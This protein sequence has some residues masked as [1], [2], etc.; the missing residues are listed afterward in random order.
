[1]LK[2]YLDDVQAVVNTFA[3]A[4]FVVQSTF[5]IDLRPGH[6][7]YLTGRFYFVDGS[8]LH[9]RE[10]VDATGPTIEKV[11]YTYHYQ[12]EEHQLIFRYDNAHHRPPLAF[13]EHK[14]TP[15]IIIQA[16]APSLEAVLLEIVELRQFDHS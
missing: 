7:A 8:V 16:K 15:D 12:D 3:E 11:S 5:D 1:M 2:T 9:F 14:H 6:Q 4:P 13:K 10:Y